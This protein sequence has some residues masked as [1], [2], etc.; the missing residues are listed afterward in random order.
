MA[1]MQ[2]QAQPQAQPQPIM[3]H[4]VETPVKETTVGDVILGSLGLTGV[5]VLA[6]IVLGA[7]L[8]AA[9]ITYKRVRAK[10]GLEPVPDAEALRI[11]PPTTLNSGHSRP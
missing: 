10:Y 8:G 5:F 3:I 1:V 6:A 9:L 2:S 7:L 4:V 11:A